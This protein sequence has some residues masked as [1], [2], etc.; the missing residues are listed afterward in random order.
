VIDLRTKAV[1]VRGTAKDVE[2]VADLLTV[3]DSPED[4][5]A[6]A[7]K[8]LRAF[9]PKRDAAEVYTLLRRLA[10]DVPCRTVAVGR[11]KLIVARGGDEA[12]KEL[13]EV[14]RELDVPAK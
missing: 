12:L 5:P 14:I 4:K 6:P 13:A 8:T 1:I 7:V 10:P 3:L 11:M 9:R 2:L